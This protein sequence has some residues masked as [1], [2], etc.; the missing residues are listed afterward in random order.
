MNAKPLLIVLFASAL[1]LALPF[2]LAPPFESSKGGVEQYFSEEEVIKGKAYMRGRHLL[3]LVSF[4]WKTALLVFLLLTPA[5]RALEAL[6][7]SLSSGKPW[8]VPLVYASS[9][10]FI[11]HLTMAPIGFYRDYLREKAF[12]LSTQTLQGWLLDQLE[13]IAIGFVLFLPL[14]LVLYAL[15]RRFPRAWFLPAGLTAAFMILLLTVLVPVA[16]EPLFYQFRPLEDPELRE[17][18]LV[19]AEKAGIRTERILEVNAS[20]RTRK[21]NAYVAGLLGTKRVVLYDTLLRGS[22]PEEVEAVLAHE[23]GHWRLKHL[24]KGV[25]FASLFVLGGLFFASKAIQ[26]GIQKGFIIQPAHIGGLPLL[27]LAFLL[28]N[29]MTLPLQ[30]SL[31][32]RFE[33][34]ADLEALRLTRDPGTFIRSEVKLARSNLADP[35][36]SPVFV[37]FF[38]T[39]PPVMERIG[40]AG[41]SFQTRE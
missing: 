32:R 1:L 9:L 3:F 27:L 11:Y 21:A 37:Y 20:K 8:L 28:F 36:P 24:W 33:R 22:S 34:E 13:W 10:Y 39:H 29:A 2:Y 38:Y 16:I 12:G 17:R 26:W 31:S 35:D 18:A 41:A 23:L 6:S 15:I 4:G 14:V 30:N 5:S 19:L 25:G 40:L 7:E